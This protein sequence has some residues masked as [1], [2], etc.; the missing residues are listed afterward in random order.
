MVVVGCWLGLLSSDGLTGAGGSASELMCSCDLQL[1]LTVG[2]GNLISC[3][4]GPLRRLFECPPDMV[5]G[6]PQIKPSEREQGGIDDAFYE[7]TSEITY[8]YYSHS[9]F[10]RCELLSLVH[11]WDD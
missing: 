1:L 5:G 10:V 2:G 4:C 7:S 6:F 11:T 3:Q 8:C 9:L